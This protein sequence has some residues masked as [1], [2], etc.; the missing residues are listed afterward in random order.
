MS[1]TELKIVLDTNILIAIIGRRS[2]YRWLFDYLI[3]GRIGLC[4]TNEI[5]LE[6]EEVLA[7]KAPAAVALNVV[8]FIETHPE[9]FKVNVYFRFDLIAEDPDDNKFVDCLISANADYLVS[10]DSHFQVLKKMNFPKVAVLTLDEFES[11][12]GPEFASDIDNSV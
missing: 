9:T 10:N 12:F 2:P 8:N 1:I 11:R 5:L 6:Y 7:R 4:V 3:E